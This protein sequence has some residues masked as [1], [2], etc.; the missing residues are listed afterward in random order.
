MAQSQQFKLNIPVDLKRWVAAEAAKSMRSQSAQIIFLL[1]EKMQ[2]TAGN[3]LQAT[4]PAVAVNT[5]ALQGGN[6]THG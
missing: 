3:S 6:V 1:R 4:D 5:A 2:T